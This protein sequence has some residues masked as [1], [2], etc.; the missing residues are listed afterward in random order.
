[1]PNP[2]RCACGHWHGWRTE[3]PG[4]CCSGAGTCGRFGRHAT[5]KEDSPS[6]GMNSIDNVSPR[7]DLFRRMDAW[8]IT[9]ALAHRGDLCCL[10][11]D[12]AGRSALCV[13]SRCEFAGHTIRMCAGSGERRHKDAI[14]Q[15]QRSKLN[16]F[17]EGRHSLLRWLDD[18]GGW[19]EVPHAFSAPTPE[20][21]WRRK[22]SLADK[23]V[24][25]R[26]RVQPERSRRLRRPGK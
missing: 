16:R 7:S 20:Q 3:L 24:S 9:V 18:A 6:T 4:V 11:N 1:V 5:L 15:D 10:G 23:G 19:G 26:W 21:A 8:S 22:L 14:G 2:S 25:L 17:E 13:I 12:E